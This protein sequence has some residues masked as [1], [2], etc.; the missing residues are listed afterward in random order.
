M[1]IR[2][3]MDFVIDNQPLYAMVSMPLLGNRGI[4]FVTLCDHLQGEGCRVINRHGGVALCNPDYLDRMRFALD[5]ILF[6]K[7]K[8]EPEL[9]PPPVDPAQER[10]PEME[11][12]FEDL[13]PNALRDVGESLAAALG[14]NQT[15]SATPPDSND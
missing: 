13:R 12:Y 8:P 9:K 5:N 10:I 3:D 6:E 7:P 15:D 1:G 2:F 11:C 14:V 4:D